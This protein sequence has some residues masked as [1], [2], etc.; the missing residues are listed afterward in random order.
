MTMA[1]DLLKVVELLMGTADGDCADTALKF[2]D[3]EQRHR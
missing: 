2:H 3:V 1:G